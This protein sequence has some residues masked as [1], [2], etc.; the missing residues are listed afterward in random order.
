MYGAGAGHGGQGG[1]S[2]TRP[3]GGMYYDSVA[4]PDLPGSAARSSPGSGHVIPGGGL[5]KF[6]VL[7]QANIDGKL[8]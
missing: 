4:D 3:G 5:L 2:I 8:L 7:Q 1:A 6:E